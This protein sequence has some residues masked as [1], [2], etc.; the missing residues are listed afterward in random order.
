MIKKENKPIRPEIFELFEKTVKEITEERDNP[1]LIMFYSDPAGTIQ[2]CDIDI[3][4]NIFED[5]LKKKDKKGFNKLDLLI[6]TTGGEAN[7]SYR[8][9]QLIRTYCKYLTVLVPTHSYSGGTLIAF[10]AEKIL[11]GRSATLSPIDIQI[12]EDQPNF[13]L[14]SIEKYQEFLDNCCN[15]YKLKDEKNKTN[16]LIELTKELVEE[17]SPTMLGEL[18]RLKSI[19]ELHS[20]TLLHNYMFKNSSNKIKIAEEIVSK[21]TTKSPTHTFEM[22][23]QLVKETGLNVELMEQK[24][25]IS[26]KKLISLCTTL[27]RGGVICSFFPK[28]QTLRIPYFDIFDVGGSKFY[29]EK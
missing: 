6:H 25:Y 15:L 5:Y 8:L 23:Y 11:M 20:K 27:K 10:G 2:P 13:S 9:I 28:S 19:T 14:L 18:F 7:T 26:L 4:E 3:L 24:F 29:G 21:F 12:G 22:D 17:V 16:F 1:L